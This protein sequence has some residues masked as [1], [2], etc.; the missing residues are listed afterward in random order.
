MDDLKVFNIKLN[1]DVNDDGST[2]VTCPECEGEI[3]V[4]FS[5]VVDD[6]MALAECVVCPLCNSRL[7]QV[8]PSEA[9]IGKIADH[10]ARELLK[11]LERDLGQTFNNLQ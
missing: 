5:N 10:V 4:V 8:H 7:D 3:N 11:S 1:M 9:L 6:S 2:L